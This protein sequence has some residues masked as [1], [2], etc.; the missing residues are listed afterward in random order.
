MEGKRHEQFKSLRVTREWFK[1]EDALLSFVATLRNG[2]VVATTEADTE[3]DVKPS[4]A[5]KKT[6]AR[7]TRKKQASPPT[8]TDFAK[9]RHAE[10]KVAIF[11]YW[12]S[13]NPDIDCPWAAPEGMQLEMWLRASPNVTIEQFKNMLRNRYRSPVNHATRPSVWLKNVSC[14][15]NGLAD[16]YGKLVKGNGHTNGNGVPKPPTQYE[17]A[18]DEQ[19]AERRTLLEKVQ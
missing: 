8:K 15:A 17:I 11:E 1:K 2:S 10:F 16:D 19:L 7:R 14:W 4:P 5:A 6:A 9:T 13:K 12:K 18:R 3:A